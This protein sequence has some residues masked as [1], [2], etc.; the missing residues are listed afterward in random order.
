[1]NS[2]YTRQERDE[3]IIYNPDCHRQVQRRHGQFFSL[4]LYRQ[5][6]NTIQVSL[7]NID[8]CIY[9]EGIKVRYIIKSV[10]TNWWWVSKLRY[11]DERVDRHDGHVRLALSIVHQVQIH[12]LFQ[13]Q[14]VGLHAVHHIGEQRG[15]VFP[16]CHGSNDL[17]RELTYI[18]IYICALLKGIMWHDIIDKMQYTKRTHSLAVVLH[19]FE[20]TEVKLIQTQRYVKCPLGRHIF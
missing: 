7:R 15:H 12:Q 3:E 14:I 2:E 16:Y 10:M 17:N 18:Y 9:V 1:M 20:M 19:R 13:L 5:T 8:I 4:P 6:L 11:L